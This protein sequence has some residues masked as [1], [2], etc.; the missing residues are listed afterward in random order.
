VLVRVTLFD[1]SLNACA[2]VR[3][4]AFRRNWAENRLKADYE[5]EVRYPCN[6]FAF[7]FCLRSV[8]HFSVSRVELNG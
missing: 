1:Q 6:M 8:A 7:P 2:S 4:S 3:S 5:H